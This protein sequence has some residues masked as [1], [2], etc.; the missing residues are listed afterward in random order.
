MV[1]SLRKQKGFTLV[2]VIVVAVIVAALAAV[3]I[4]VYLNYVTSARQNSAQNAGGALA[5]FCGACIN[6]AGTITPALVATGGGTLT[7]SNGA[8]INVPDEVIATDPTSLTAAGGAV[9]AAHAVE[10]TVYTFN[11]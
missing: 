9:T 2:E 8:T 7:C 4:G 5:S 11:Y 10:G 6:S 3:A 1:R